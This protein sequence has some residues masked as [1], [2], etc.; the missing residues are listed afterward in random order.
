M[1]EVIFIIFALMCASIIG[2]LVYD[3]YIV[4]WKCTSCKSINT[5]NMDKDG[6]RFKDH[7]KCS[8]CDEFNNDDLLGI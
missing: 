3:V 1:L 6:I 8:H 4:K 2:Y 7:N 5:G